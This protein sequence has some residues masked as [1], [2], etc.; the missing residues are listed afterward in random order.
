VELRVRTTVNLD[1][2]ERGEETK[3]IL[4]SHPNILPKKD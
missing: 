4:K 2:K 3:G 1:W